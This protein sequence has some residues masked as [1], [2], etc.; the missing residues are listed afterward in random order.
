[1]QIEKIIS[2]G[3]VV[4][5]QDDDALQVALVGR[6]DL[7]MWG[8]PKGGPEEGETL[9]EAA[10]RETS[11]ETGLQLRFLGQVGTIK[12]NFM[13]YAQDRHYFK[14]VHYFLMEAIGGDIADHDEEHDWVQWFNLDEA[15]HTIVYA[16]EVNIIRRAAEMW[17]ELKGTNHAG[18]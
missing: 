4:L 8:L 11:E 16:N 15:L 1:M 7:D 3:G 13:R 5:R 14:T 2:A 12:Y 17:Q 10:M 18:G 9:L 6:S